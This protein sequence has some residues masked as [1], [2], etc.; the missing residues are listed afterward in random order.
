M[1]ILDEYVKSAPSPQHALDIF[2]GEWASILPTAY[3][4]WKAGS[5]PLFEDARLEWFKT[6]IGG[7]EGRTVLELGP[8]EAGH[9]Y[10]CEHSGAVEITAIEANT[11][12]YL[13]CLIIKEVLELKRT[14]FL[15]GDFVEYLRANQA[16]FDVCLA[17]G[18]LY[19]VLNPVELIALAARAAERLFLWTHYY[20]RAI[21]KRTSYLSVKFTAHEKSVYEGFQH[22]LHR[23]EYQSTLAQ[24]GFCGGSA[25]FS[26][27]L[28]REEILACLEYFGFKNL[29]INLEDPAHPHGP[30]FTVAAWR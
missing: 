14:R 17:S 25:P 8:L 29:R 9:S 1:S 26:H 16:T 6:Q 11:R 30:C 15:C 5:I 20:D 10:M 13:K 12:A 19:H 3:A 4:H 23:H 21:I 18:V 7:L 2:K 24:K 28:S 27:W 22:T